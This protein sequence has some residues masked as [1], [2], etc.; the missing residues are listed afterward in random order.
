MI[1]FKPQRVQLLSFSQLFTIY[2]I[3]FSSKNPILKIKS[4][5]TTALA[6]EEQG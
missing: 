1:T 6:M 5:L 4:N 3:R 2:Y